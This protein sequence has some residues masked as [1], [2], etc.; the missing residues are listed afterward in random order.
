MAVHKAAICW[1]GITKDSM[2]RRIPT[3]INQIQSGPVA[4]RVSDKN[5]LS[6]RYM[7]GEN[8]VHANLLKI[9]CHHEEFVAGI[10]TKDAA[11]VDDFIRRF[12]LAAIQNHFDLVIEVP[13]FT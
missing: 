1:D 2:P 6:I 9:G 13:S 12:K 8:R 4:Q 10:T 5:V 11:K 7:F 3:Q